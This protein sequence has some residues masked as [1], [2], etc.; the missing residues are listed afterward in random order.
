ML[1]L[2]DR[3]KAPGLR[4]E[5]AHFFAIAAVLLWFVANLAW[6]S[7]N[8]SGGPRNIDEDGYFALALNSYFAGQRDGWS[9]WVSTAFAAGL[10]APLVPAVTSA[11]FFVTGPRF[12]TALA[13]VVAAGAITI[14]LVY[15]L[16]R[17]ASGRRAGW[18]A[19]ILIATLP[20]LIQLSRTFIFATPAAAVTVAAVYA[21]VR[22]RCMTS[23][24]WSLI[25]GVLVGLM[26]LS[27][28]M[29]VAF[30]PGL[31]AV[32]FFQLIFVPGGRKARSARALV[33]GAV[34]AVVAGLWLVPSWDIVLGYLTGYGFGD[35]ADE[36]SGGASL[37]FGPALASLARTTFLT[38][39][40][41]FVAALVVGVFLARKTVRRRGWK[42]VLK[43]APAHPAVMSGVVVAEGMLALL[44]SRNGGLGFA[45]PLLPLAVIAAAACF[46]SASRILTR[47]WVARGLVAAVT[48]P[49]LFLSLMFVFSD[50]N[51]AAPRNMVLPGVGSIPVTQGEGLDPAYGIT[52]TDFGGAQVRQGAWTSANDRLFDVLMQYSPTGEPLPLA[53]GFRNY[54]VNVNSTQ[55][56]VLLEQESPVPVAQI[57]PTSLAPSIDGYS[58]WLSSGN[59]G[60]SCML[61]TSSGTQDEFTPVADQALLERAATTSGFVQQASLVLPDERVVHIWLR[62]SHPECAI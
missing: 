22:S 39:L 1:R 47:R 19:L 13:V 55:V 23:W 54:Y 3:H 59:A 7:A 17:R 16:A 35:H 14:Y 26:P 28:T 31:V 30:V 9:A 51:L 41:L 36:Y 5:Y 42:A 45:L 34:A 4:I 38:H 21:L 57:D 43:S 20:G 50:S 44:S 24:R 49:P 25:F 53:F 58:A 8:R 12:A 48:V 27:R 40:L 56:R 32:V 60:G 29:T 52:V 2:R 61:L 62:A 11:L 18:I 46:A 10:Q 37:V 15:A 6:L 33:A